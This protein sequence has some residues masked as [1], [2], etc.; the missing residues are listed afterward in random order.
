MDSEHE[1]SPCIAHRARQGS[2]GPASS[3]M[4]SCSPNSSMTLSKEAESSRPASSPKIETSLLIFAV[5]CAIGAESLQY[6][7]TGG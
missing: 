6:E 7:T 5:P 1:S 3:P 4:E 2:A